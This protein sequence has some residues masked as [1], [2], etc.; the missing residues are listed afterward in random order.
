MLSGFW[1][2]VLQFS[3]QPANAL[4]TDFIHH[5]L[6]DL[7]LAQRDATWTIF[8]NNN[9]KER[10]SAVSLVIEWALDYKNNGITEP[11]AIQAIG[12]TLFWFLGSTNRQLRDYATKAAIF[13]F[14]ENIA[15]L[16]SVMVDFEKVND[17][18]ITQKNLRSCFGCGHKK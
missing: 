9:Y 2:E 16:K 18:Y 6:R 7:T 1:S 15:L 14:I 17:P 8:I 5:Y 10:G 13:L 12:K 4:N 3:F 11:K